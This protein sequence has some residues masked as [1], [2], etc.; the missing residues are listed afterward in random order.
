M[1][2]T[3]WAIFLMTIILLSIVV[4]AEISSNPFDNNDDNH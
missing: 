4:V 2:F 1:K 3:S